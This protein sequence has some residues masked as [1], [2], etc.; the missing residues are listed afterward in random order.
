VYIG[1]KYKVG[2][3]LG[4]QPRVSPCLQHSLD[5]SDLIINH[6]VINRSLV[7]PIM[8]LHVEG[9]VSGVLVSFSSRIMMIAREV[10]SVEL[11]EP[12]GSL[13]AL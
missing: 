5:C 8:T 4:P 13:L 6:L 10:K 11:C 12:T 3:I 2:L 1:E 9:A 7:A